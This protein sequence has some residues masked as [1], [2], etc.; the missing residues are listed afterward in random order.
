MS[1]VVEVWRCGFRG[2]RLQDSD[3][4]LKRVELGL[5]KLKCYVTTLSARVNMSTKICNA[6]TTVVRDQR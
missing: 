1:S 6:K 5:I 4:G 2:V 3:D